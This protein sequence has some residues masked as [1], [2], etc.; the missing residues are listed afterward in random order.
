MDSYG[1]SKSAVQK[2]DPKD[3]V[4]GKLYALLQTHWKVADAEGIR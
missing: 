1:L 2:G 4:L 3:M